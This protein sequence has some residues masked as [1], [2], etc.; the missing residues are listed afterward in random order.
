LNSGISLPSPDL[1]N[2]APSFGFSL[3]LILIGLKTIGALFTA[4]GTSL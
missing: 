3:S 2:S 4:P 1:C